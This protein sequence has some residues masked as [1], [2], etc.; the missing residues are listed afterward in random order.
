MNQFHRMRDASKLLGIA[1]P[2]LYAHIVKGIF[3]P[4]ISVGP[5]ATAWPQAELDAIIAART[6]GHT[7][8]QIRALVS[9]MTAAR[10][11][12]A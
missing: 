4:G 1:K 10:K 6:A 7:E 5:R 2:T 11:L 3:P 8:E 12:A 9:S